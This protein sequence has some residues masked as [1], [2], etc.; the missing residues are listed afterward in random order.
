MLIST[1]DILFLKSYR[2]DDTV[3][4]GGIS[5]L[6]EIT[7]DELSNLFRDVPAEYVFW[8]GSRYRKLFL[9]NNASGTNTFNGVG[10]CVFIDSQS[11][12]FFS[13]AAGT[14]S[15]STLEA[16]SYTQYHICGTLSS[17]ITGRNYVPEGPVTSSFSVNCKTG[18]S[19]SGFFDSSDMVIAFADAGYEQGLFSEAIA[20][21][22]PASYALSVIGFAI[23]LSLSRFR[24][25]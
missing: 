13:L 9:K 4:G 10:I 17:S 20:I 25:R 14:S 8:G 24:A 22:E 23:L 21:P 2:M 5:T 3:L 6:T 11:D 18:V 19:G 15:D 16:R 1:S 12:D 7:D